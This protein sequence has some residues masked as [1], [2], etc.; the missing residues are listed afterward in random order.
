MEKTCLVI[1]CSGQDGSLLC[2]SLLKKGRRV[3]GLSR[4]KK[5][6]LINHTKLGI[7]GDVEVMQGE[8]NNFKTIEKIIAKY[9]PERIFNLAAQSSVGKSF[10]DPARYSIN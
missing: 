2:N 7:D 9:Q 1:G 6:K 10:F 3:I 8:I 4:Q 5:G